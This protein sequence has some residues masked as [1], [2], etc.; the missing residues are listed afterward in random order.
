MKKL[1]AVSL[2]AGSVVSIPALSQA[3]TSPEIYGSLGYGS[4]RASGTDNGSIQ[5]R[6]GAKLT[7]HFGFEG[8]L[9]G[10]VSDDKTYVAGAPVNVDMK[11]QAAA[12]AVGFLPVTHNIDLLARAG[13]GTTKFD[14][15]SS[16]SPLK[17][18]M[19][20]WNYGVGAQYKF[21]DKN[22][23]RADWTK[24][25]Y[26]NSKEDSDTIAVAYVRKFKPRSSCGG[27]GLIRPGTAHRL[28]TGRTAPL[29]PEAGRQNSSL[30]PSAVACTVS[31]CR[32]RFLGRRP[33][34]SRRRTRRRSRRPRG[35]Y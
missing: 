15:S 17:G 8:E 14:A 23:V 10:G 22:G 5:A 33:F 25:E 16:T 28:I 6:V 21:N 34:P 26:N 35:R 30:S 13:Y 24:S 20:S 9:A 19:E 2:V 18:S 4:T 27:P 7:A 12:Y 3:Q 31:S 11:H 32:N 1:I 29:G